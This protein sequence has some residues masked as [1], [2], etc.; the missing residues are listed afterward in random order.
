M[1]DGS[2]RYVGRHHPRRLTLQLA[3]R[4]TGTAG[5]NH[6]DKQERYASSDR[7]NARLALDRLMAIAT[8]ISRNSV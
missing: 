6:K 2:S 4:K 7:R 5:R 8:L 3:R 1:P